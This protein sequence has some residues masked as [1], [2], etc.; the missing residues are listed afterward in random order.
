VEVGHSTQAEYRER[1][2]GP[3]GADSSP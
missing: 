1:A 2:R 3:A